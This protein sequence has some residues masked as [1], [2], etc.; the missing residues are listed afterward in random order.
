MD[1]SRIYWPPS[2]IASRYATTVPD[3]AVHAFL[4]HGAADRVVL[5]DAT[6]EALGKAII[7]GWTCAIVTNGRIGMQEE[8]I[9][10]TDWTA[11]STAG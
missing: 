7:D 10:K 8:K 5:P 2:A 9:R 4:D 11:S 6:C 1:Q 3:S